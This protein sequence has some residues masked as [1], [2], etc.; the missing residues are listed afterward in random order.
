[1]KTLAQLRKHYA[2]APKDSELT[3]IL[4]KARV[5]PSSARYLADVLAY[6]DAEEMVKK[7]Y[8]AQALTS[9][10]RPP[11]GK[12]SAILTAQKKNIARY[13]RDRL[14]AL[15]AD[16][17]AA[18]LPFLRT[19]GEGADG[20]PGFLVQAPTQEVVRLARKYGQRRVLI[21]SQGILDMTTG[22]VAPR[23]GNDKVGSHAGTSVTLP[24]GRQFSFEVPVDEEAS[25]PLRES[26]Q[27]PQE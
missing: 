10:Y 6:P 21:H 9:L 2:N 24:S 15:E 25:A 22:K 7:A 8:D 23:S 26:I 12:V 19:Q 18:K 17:R 14:R 1:M 27:N 3:S 13:D 20:E 16:L 4:E 5:S 11:R